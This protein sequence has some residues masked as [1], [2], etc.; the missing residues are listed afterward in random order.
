MILTLVH[1]LKDNFKMNLWFR[2]VIKKWVKKILNHL[3]F[4][5]KIYFKWHDIK[6]KRICDP[7]EK[8]W[9]KKEFYILN[10][11][12]LRFYAFFWFLYNFKLSFPY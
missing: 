2:I 9:I 11:E 6:K 12:F 7:M 5:F 4:S 8:I 1:A 10:Y 3:I